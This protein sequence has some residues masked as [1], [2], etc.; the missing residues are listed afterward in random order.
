MRRAG[1]DAR[2]SADSVSFV[3]SAAAG[4]PADDMAELDAIQSVYGESLPIG[5]INAQIGHAAG[6]SAGLSIAK[7]TFELQEQEL[8]MPSGRSQQCIS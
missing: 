8:R 7:T 4:V 1:E 2:I 6:A 5:A 3:E